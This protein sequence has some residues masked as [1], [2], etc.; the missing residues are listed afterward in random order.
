MAKNRGC[1]KELISEMHLLSGEVANISA[2]LEKEFQ[3]LNG[4]LQRYFQLIITANCVRQTGQSLTILL[5]HVRA[6]LD[7]LILGHLSPSIVI[8]GHLRELLLG[9]QTKLLHHLRLPIDPV[10]ELWKYYNAIRRG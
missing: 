1:I 8:S 9:I 6:Q 7:M 2:A 4:F 3:E 10:K 5:E